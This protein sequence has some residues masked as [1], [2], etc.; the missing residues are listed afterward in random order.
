MVVEINLGR[1]FSHE[2]VKLEVVNASHLRD[3]LVWKIL[4]IYSGVVAEAIIRAPFYP[5]YVV[6]GNNGY[7]ELASNYHRGNFP[8]LLY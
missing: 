5:E 7:C 1:K 6:A 2:K 3:H 4:N 8:V